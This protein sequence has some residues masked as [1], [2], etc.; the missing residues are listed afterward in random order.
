MPGSTPFDAQ[1]P[2]DYLTKLPEHVLAAFKAA[3]F[4]LGKIPEWVPPKELR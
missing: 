1:L 3:K 2:A 4:E